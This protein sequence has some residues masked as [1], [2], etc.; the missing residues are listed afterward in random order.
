MNENYWS[1][2][3]VPLGGT[4][5]KVEAVNL[6]EN[7]ITIDASISKNGKTENV[8]IP[9]AYLPILKKHIANAKF[10]DFLFSANN[11]KPGV[12][13]LNPKKI[14]D[15]WTKFRK[16]K[17]IPNIYQFYSLKDTG[18]TDLLNSGIPAIKVRDQAR[19]HDLKITESYTARNQNC[20]ESVRNSNVNF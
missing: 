7:Y 16:Q 17:D 19:H 13:Q 6:N 9:N 15:D 12:K 10:D 14:S 5:L 3:S 20:D 4:K 8:T 18:I 2:T 1:I 11:F